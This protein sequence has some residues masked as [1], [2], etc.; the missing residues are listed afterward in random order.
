MGGRQSSVTEERPRSNSVDTAQVSSQHSSSQRAN[1]MTAAEFMQTMRN[2]RFLSSSSDSNASEDDAGPS[3]STTHGNR[4]RGL[5]ATPG[6]LHGHHSRRS[7]PVFMMDMKCP[8]CHKV[9]PSDDADIHLVMCLT[10]PK[11]TY[12]D[13]VLKDDKGECSICLED[14]EAGHKIARLPCLCIY[15]KQCIDDWFKRKNCCPEHPGD[16]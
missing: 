10:R 2:A 5:H 13:D 7:V 6:R 15:H 3:H 8:V 12:N 11:I 4:S 14:L 1:V 9:V 16:D